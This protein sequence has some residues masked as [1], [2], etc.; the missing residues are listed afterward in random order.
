MCGGIDDGY[1]WG[2]KKDPR[3]VKAL[4]RASKM[5]A[6]PE[7][8]ERVAGVISADQKSGIADIPVGD[9]EAADLESGKLRDHT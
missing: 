9:E 8:A 2:Q 4:E 1:A 3:I 5:G 7:M 6:T